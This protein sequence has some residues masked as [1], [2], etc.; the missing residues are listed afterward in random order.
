[1]TKNIQYQTLSYKPFLWWYIA[2]VRFWV[3]DTET[4][5]IDGRT[6]GIKHFWFFRRRQPNF[7]RDCIA[8]VMKNK[9]TRF[10]WEQRFLKSKDD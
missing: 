3:F 10:R 1:M 6:F 7:V 4:Q 2:T 8:A 5:M 9:N